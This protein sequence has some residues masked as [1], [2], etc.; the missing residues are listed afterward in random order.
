MSNTAGAAREV[1]V[2]LR[3]RDEAA[4]Q[5]LGEDVAAVLKAGDIVMLAGGLGA[6]KTTFARALIRALAGDPA[7]EVQSPTFPLR[8]DHAL[9]RLTIAHVD[10]YRVGSASELE[11]IG[12]DDAV[13]EGALIVEWPEQLPGDLGGERLQ[14][15]FEIDGE[16]REVAIVAAGSWPTRLAQTARI[17]A[18]LGEA[19]QR[20]ATRVPLAGDASTRA[21]ERIFLEDGTSIL[22]NA[23]ARSEGPAI[24]D[25]RSY[26]AIAHRALD[27]KPF[28]AIDI[29]LRDAGIRAPEIRAADMSS[30]ILL[31][32]DFGDE[33]I[34][35]ASG[36]PI[37]ERYEAAID[38]LVEMHSRPW[39]AEAALPS[40]ETYALPPYDRDALMIEV[41]LFPDWFVGRGGEAPMT[42]ERRTKFLAAWLRLFDKVDPRVT[43]WV[44]RDFHSPNILWQAGET[45]ISRV[46][47]IDFQDALIGHPAYDVASLAQDARVTLDEAAE[48]HLKARYH[49]G[50]KARDELGFDPVAFDIAYIILALQRATKVL[51]GFA[52]LAYSDRKTGYQR[53]RGRLKALLRRN[54][55]HSV[56]SD[57]RV[58]YEPYL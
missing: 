12:L 37:L 15:T 46:G 17:R 25:G 24:Y 51:G 40:G 18:F 43:T 35:D 54:L 45:G 22:M 28:V 29:A 1:R 10:L 52:R 21:Y 33:G 20:G 19:G 27:A 42:E 5:H 50:R 41:S 48:A 3:L 8:L 57:M 58:W 56:L 49:A 32:E 16:G 38:L 34:V 53:H 55:A 14:L 31:L 36:A 11:E 23:P 47:I 13:A 4:T 2:S 26:D 9:P 6:G 39:P 7:H 30:G 44:M